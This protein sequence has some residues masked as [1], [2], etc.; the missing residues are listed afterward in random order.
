L[1]ASGAPFSNGR[2]TKTKRQ[3]GFALVFLVAKPP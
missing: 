2:L 1:P 3:S